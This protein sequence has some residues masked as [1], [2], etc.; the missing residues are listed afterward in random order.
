MAS[1]LDTKA[2]LQSIASRKNNSAIAI[3]IDLA[4]DDDNSICSIA[5]AWLG[6]D[7]A[8]S[9]SYLVKPPTDDFSRARKV[10]AAMTAESQSFADIWDQGVLPLLKGDVLAMYDAN[11]TLRRLRA[12]YEVSGRIFTLPE[13]YIRDLRFL[14]V[15][16]L[17]RLGNDS[18]IS[19]IHRLRLTADLD[20]TASRAIA[21]TEALD[22]MQ[23]LYP[24][25]GYGVPLSMVLSGA[26]TLPQDLAE[27]EQPEEEPEEEEPLTLN[28]RLNQATRLGLI[29]ILVIAIA[30][31]GYFLYRQQRLHAAPVDFSSY[32]STEVP[33]TE[34]KKY[35][36][37]DQTKTYM[38]MRG[39]YL[40][41][42][43]S[44]IDLFVVAAREH[45]ANKIRSMMRSSRVIV[46]QSTV[47][48]EVT[49]PTRPSGFV[50]IRVKGGD[51]TGQR[52]YASFS[53][54]NTARNVQNETAN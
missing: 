33:K 24:A 39:S 35:P 22:R 29:P 11:T 54:I 38:M 8:H 12:S 14:A 7:R 47:T 4:N 13:I 32:S 41:L 5:V 45:D 28:E 46:F 34:Q 42:D 53:M 6:D 49:G 3:A 2:I 15:T 20:N 23:R 26:L 1:E 9:V 40:I 43:E 50:P 52:G 44:D 16:Y 30:L 51:H 25:S 37:F 10:T 36:D 27:P 21:C 31:F 48:I 19:I 18:F 17:P